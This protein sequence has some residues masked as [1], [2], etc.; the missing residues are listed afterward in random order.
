MRARLLKLVNGTDPEQLEWFDFNEDVLK[1]QVM[2]AMK[3]C[4]PEDSLLLVVEDKEEGQKIVKFDANFVADLYELM[5]EIPPA[6]LPPAKPLMKLESVWAPMEEAIDILTQTILDNIE[7][8]LK[9]RLTSRLRH[10]ARNTIEKSVTQVAEEAGHMAKVVIIGPKK[11]QFDRVVDALPPEILENYEFQFLD[12]NKKVQKSG[13]IYVLWTKYISHKT[14]EQ[15]EALADKQAIRK[16][17]HFSPDELV[18]AIMV[19]QE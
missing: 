3:A 16:I 14:Q 17:S 1:K 8:Q 5:P 13:D 15:V 10:I 9:R 6:L 11:N 2:Q 4:G 12:K 18:N 7:P 19:N